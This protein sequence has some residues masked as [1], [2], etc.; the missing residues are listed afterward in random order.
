MCGLMGWVLYGDGRRLGASAD[1]M[2]ALA[3]ARGEDSAGFAGLRHGR[4]LV[5]RWMGPLYVNRDMRRCTVVIAHS[6]AATTGRVCVEH[7][8]PLHVAYG[9]RHIWLTHNGGVANYRQILATP[10]VRKYI[11]DLRR[12]GE[13]DTWEVDS[14]L[15]YTSPSPR[16]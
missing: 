1:A 10:K 3:A 6:R 13:P 11:E 5:G 2:A 14:C 16:D 9:G 15:L 12:R 8:H 4:L 7:A